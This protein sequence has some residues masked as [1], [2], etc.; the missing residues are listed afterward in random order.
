[1]AKAATIR[2]SKGA[3]INLTK[4]FEALLL[5][6]EEH[7]NKAGVSWSEG[8]KFITQLNSFKKLFQETFNNDK[9]KPSPIPS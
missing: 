5:L 2:V 4:E 9:P 6:W 3:A 8:G 7:S 1:M